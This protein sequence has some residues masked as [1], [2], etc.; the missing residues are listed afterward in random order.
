MA[1]IPGG[2]ALI[3][4]T[5]TAMLFGRV[6]TCRPK[7]SWTSRRTSR[8]GFQA[9]PCSSRSLRLVPCNS[10]FRLIAKDKDLATKDDDDLNPI[11]GERN[12]AMQVDGLEAIQQP[13][14]RLEAS[15]TARAS[16]RPA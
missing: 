5:S 8:V 14:P 7:F 1:R 6:T 2:M 9:L 10:I 4:R 11:D 3:D 16:D 13:D 15:F 12:L